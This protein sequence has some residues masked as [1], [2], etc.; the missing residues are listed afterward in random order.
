[1]KFGRMACKL[2]NPFVDRVIA[3]LRRNTSFLDELDSGP[4]E[5]SRSPMF[6]GMYFTIAGVG[7]FVVSVICLGMVV[8]ALGAL[9]LGLWN[10]WDV[11]LFVLYWAAWFL[12]FLFMGVYWLGFVFDQIYVGAVWLFTNGALWSGVFSCIV[13]A[14]SWILGAGAV[15]ITLCVV[16]LGISKIPIAKRFG[17]Y[18]VNKFNGYTEAQEERE[19][20][21]KKELKLKEAQGWVCKHCNHSSDSCLAR[22]D[23]CGRFNPKP[24]NPFFYPLFV[25]WP[26]GWVLVQLVGFSV[27]IKEREIDVLG[28]LGIVW[29]YLVAIKKGV[30]PLIE[31]VDPAQLQA[32][33]DEKEDDESTQD[34]TDG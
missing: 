14:V 2:Q 31:F 34:P 15:A 33:G 21:A 17:G 32:D 19:Q 23:Q 8:S 28:P 6:T 9:G 4:T 18:L 24:V 11:G 3:L 20:R 25:F 7:M 22:C 29:Q 1:M 16:G 5:F 12:S 27:K 30:C 26:V 10:I 13:W